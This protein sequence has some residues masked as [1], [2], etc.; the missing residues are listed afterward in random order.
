MNGILQ[1]LKAWWES[2]DRTQKIVTLGGGGLMLALLI[3]TFMIASKPKMS[4]VFANL[5]PG[6]AGTVQM[7]IEGM[8]IP[9]TMDTGGNIS[10]PSDKIALVRARLAQNNKLPKSPHPGYEGLTSMGMMNT[11]KVEEE[12]LKTMLEGELSKSAE[13]FDGVDSARVHLTFGIDSP[14]ATEK[15]DATASVTLAERQAGSVTPDEGRAIATLV[16]SSV[17]GLD[18]KKVAIFSRDGRA[19]YDGTSGDDASGQAL[20]K[21]Q[22]E[23]KEGEIR[24]NELQETLNRVVGPG[25]A[26]VTVNLTV[27]NSPM[28]EESDVPLVD[29]TPTEDHTLKETMKGDAT[30]KPAI[31]TSDDLNNQKQPMS[32]DD[33]SG[34]K[35]GYNRTQNGIYRGAVGVTH[36]TTTKGLGD[37]KSMMVT[38]FLNRPKADPNAADP[39]QADKDAAEKEEA[40][41]RA[42]NTY[43]G[44][45][46][47]NPAAAV[48]PLSQPLAFTAKDGFGAEIISY[49]FDDKVQKESEKASTEV[50]G[51][52]KMSQIISIVPIAVL[53]ILAF[54]VMA[55]LS[56]LGRTPSQAP[57]YAIAGGGYSSLPMGGG[58]VYEDNGELRALPMLSVQ[59]ELRQRALDSGISE[60]ELNAAMAAAGEKGLNLEDIPSIGKRINLPLEQIRKMGQERP[61]VVAML[62]KSWLLE[63]RR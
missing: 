10:V 19:I 34:G 22:V 44:L 46:K 52:Q 42:V 33:K 55:K 17:P 62:V 39:A 36:R 18:S 50:A 26:L 14:F 61:E 56:K 43:L 4:I 7:D 63:D 47:T 15:K 51:Q 60:E 12:R 37:L 35:D 28:H 31:G 38:V 59:E 53:A 32:V 1:K 2:A 54:V 58:T 21:L 16:A 24:R 30:G 6:D 25:N 40:V 29:K 48:P 27:D 45:A 9:V 20:T 49:P 23:K 13:M 11:P 3:G 41:R 8:G 57:Q 5:A